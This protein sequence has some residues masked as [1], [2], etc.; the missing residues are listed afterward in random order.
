M[1]TEYPCYQQ[2]KDRSGH[3]YWVYYGKNYEEIARSSESY[4][5]RSDC[6]HSI[7]LMKNSAASKVYYFE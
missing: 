1:D 5:N 3:W 7:Q 4:V 6:L 2:R